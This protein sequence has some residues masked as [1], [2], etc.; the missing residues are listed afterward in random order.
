LARRNA[1]DVFRR[2]ASPVRRQRVQVETASRGSRRFHAL[3]KAIMPNIASST[4][5]LHNRRDLP[6]GRSRCSQAS[7]PGHRSTFGC[8]P[9]EDEGATRRL[10]LYRGEP[11]GTKAG[12]G[13][14]RSDTKVGAPARELHRA[15]EDSRVRECDLMMCCVAS[16]PR[17]PSDRHRPSPSRARKRAVLLS[18]FARLPKSVGAT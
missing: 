1:Y 3:A 4:R 10:A 18:G 12:R 6:S 14:A 2:H 7:I 11:P 17:C 13:K 5:S 8:I 15:G 16:P 9:D